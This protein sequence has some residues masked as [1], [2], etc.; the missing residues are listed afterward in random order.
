MCAPVS[1]ATFP[2]LLRSIR[3]W[4]DSIYSI[5]H[6]FFISAAS[7]PQRLY[8]LGPPGSLPGSP[9]F[10]LSITHPLAF[11]LERPI[12]FLCVNPGLSPANLTLASQTESCLP[13]SLTVHPQVFCA[14]VLI[15]RSY[16]NRLIHIVTDKRFHCT[17]ILPRSGWVFFFGWLWGCV[18]FFLCFVFFFFFVFVGSS[19]RAGATPPAFF[20]DT[21]PPPN[22]NL[23]Q[24]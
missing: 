13:T 20:R 10:P 18:F 9:W 1:R 17:A 24:T 7:H 2:P 22:D 21:P 3:P 15:M 11:F 19:R 5:R 14:L 12:F 16:E 23:G 4:D 8:R 6:S